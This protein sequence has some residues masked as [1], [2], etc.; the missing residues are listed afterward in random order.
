[1]SISVSVHTQQSP[2][3]AIVGIHHS[4]AVLTLQVNN[5]EVKFFVEGTDEINDIVDAIAEA[6]R[7]PRV[8]V[9]GSRMS[10]RKA[11]G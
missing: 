3:R 5:H 11:G 2:T 10:T 9:I 8:D 6:V 7:S 4:F 1:M